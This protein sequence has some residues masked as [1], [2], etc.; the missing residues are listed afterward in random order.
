MEEDIFNRT[1]PSHRP[2]KLCWFP[3]CTCG[4]QFLNS[5]PWSSHFMRSD[6]PGK[7]FCYYFSLLES[8]PISRGLWPWTQRIWVLCRTFLYAAVA[9]EER[10]WIPFPVTMG[11]WAPYTKH[12]IRNGPTQSLK[13]HFTIKFS[14]KIRTMEVIAFW[15][16]DL[17]FEPLMDEAERVKRV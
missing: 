14:K 6:F 17:S 3:S 1:P 15:W 10:F 13:C 9:E 11:L 2:Y 7:E 5:S 12:S 16:E 8:I 4:F